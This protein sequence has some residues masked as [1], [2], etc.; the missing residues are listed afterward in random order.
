MEIK[1]IRDSY[2]QGYL[3][4]VVRVG[5]A[6]FYC[7]SYTQH[8]IE[9]DIKAINSITDWADG[10]KPSM[11]KKLRQIWATQGLVAETRYDAARGRRYKLCVYPRGD[12]GAR[13]VTLAASDN[14]SDTNPEIASPVWAPTTES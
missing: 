7:C 2:N 5:N 1:L 6:Y 12:A 9:H 3:S 11:Q 4:G 13:R 8:G 14:R 10:K